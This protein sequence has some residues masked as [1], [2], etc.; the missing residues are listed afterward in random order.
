MD[1]IYIMMPFLLYLNPGLLKYAL[2]PTLQYHK[3][4]LAASRYCVY[5]I[6]EK[7]PQGSS[8][9]L[10]ACADELTL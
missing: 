1:Q 5:N 6:G 4:G 2:R 7:Y 8:S 9:F 10:E 3:A